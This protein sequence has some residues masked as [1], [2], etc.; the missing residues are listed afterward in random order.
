MKDICM[1]VGFGAGLVA[2]ALL[3]KHSQDA[4]QMVNKGEKAVK[5]EVENM[6]N[7]IESNTQ[8]MKSEIK[9]NQKSEA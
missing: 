1:L 3:Y 9:K 7:M 4:R 2:G 6:K 8:K 5:E